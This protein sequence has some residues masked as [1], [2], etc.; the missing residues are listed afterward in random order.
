MFTRNLPRVI[1]R[2]HCSWKL[3]FELKNFFVEIVARYG[4]LQPV[5]DCFL[6]CMG[7]ALTFSLLSCSFQSP[8]R[9]LS[10]CHNAVM[11]DLI[12]LL[13]VF[14]LPHCFSHAADTLYKT[15]FLVGPEPEILFGTGDKSFES[16]ST[17]GIGSHSSIS[18][19]PD[20][21]GGQNTTKS[22]NFRVTHENI[23]DDAQRKPNDAELFHHLLRNG[24]ATTSGGISRSLESV[25]SIT[26][27]ILGFNYDD[28]VTETGGASVEAD[29]NGAVGVS[30]LVAVVTSM[31][32]VRQKDGTLMFRQG[33]QNFFSSFKEASDS[34]LFFKPKVI[35]D[36]HEGRFV[37]AVLQFR[38]SPQI[39]RIWLAVSIDETP[40]TVS[41]WHQF[42][43]DS[44][45]SIGGSNAYALRTGLAVD[46]AVYVTSDM[47]RY[48]DGF[49]VGVRLWSFSKGQSDGFYAGLEF[50]IGAPVNPYLTKGFGATTLPAQVHGSNGVDGSVGT[51]FP[52]IL[53]TFGG[54][55]NLQIYTLFNPLGASPSSTLQIINLGVINDL[56]LVYPDAPQLGST[57]AIDTGD[58]R[59]MDAVWQ[60]N[61]LWVVFSINPASGV[62]QGQATAHWVRCSTS[63]GTVT[64]E[65]QGDLGGE[66]IAAGASTFFPS[67]AVNTHGV[68][69]YG[70]GASSSTMYAGA[71]ASVGTS[72]ESYTVKMGLAPYNRN[73]WGAYSG[74][75]VDPTDDSFWIFNQYAETVGSSDVS[76]LGRW[77]TAWGRLVAAPMQKPCGLFGLSLFCP[78][79]LCGLFGRWSG[80][81]HS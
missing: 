27:I 75:S 22:S 26:N 42:Y 56:N 20:T 67:V 12:L 80:L 2:K 28:D 52:A 18:L 46:E 29:P 9:V 76:G 8:T 33:F 49:G 58:G 35:Y 51:F 4:R 55:V 65:A 24:N 11:V 17:K 41:D 66:G 13:N 68:V 61:K 19:A 34:T 54:E 37:I 44:V 64:L 45:I 39:S 40:D 30:R 59:V 77:A 21:V 63:K 38:D 47:I 15:R 57:I 74:I 79:T 32:E 50:S 70:Y 43:I 72:E 62:N 73:A 6:V 78:F 5:N 16:G 10:R 31:M 69:A 23:V 36:E 14:L 25:S 48:S 7:T 53:S 81:C 60:N 1:N 71:Y 3:F